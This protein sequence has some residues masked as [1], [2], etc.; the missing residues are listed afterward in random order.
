MTYYVSSGTL[1]PT[2][3]LTHYSTFPGTPESWVPD[4][5][6]PVNMISTA[7]PFTDNI[8]PQAVLWFSWGS[9][10]QVVGTPMGLKP[11]SL[12]TY[13]LW[14][15]VLL[16]HILGFF[17]NTW[18]SWCQYT[19]LN[20]HCRENSAVVFCFTGTVSIP[21]NKSTASDADV[22]YICL[23][24]TEG[25]LQQ[26]TSNNT[27]AAVMYSMLENFTLHFRYSVPS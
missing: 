18:S 20:K 27:R 1:N 7:E 25:R 17:L 3:S 14:V 15:C 8:V 16:R 6:P 5:Y 9:L 10:L 4:I 11:H 12:Y 26:S 21:H 13:P 23:Q 19:V 22:D 2:H 24:V